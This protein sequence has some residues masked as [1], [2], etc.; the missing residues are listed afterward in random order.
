MNELNKLSFVIPCYR[1]EKTIRSV[2]E[3]I[4]RTVRLREG[5]AYEIIAVNDCS[6]DDVMRVLVELAG[7]DENFKVV[8]CAKN[9]GKH[10]ALM[11]GFR[12]V[13]GDVA[14]CVDDDCQCPVDQLWALLAPIEAGHDVAM[15]D[16]GHKAQSNV[17]NIGSLGNELMMRWLLGKPKEF[18]FSNFAAIRRFIVDEMLKYDHN[19][20]YVNGLILRST[21]DYVNVP[22]TERSRTVGRGGFTFRK[23][24]KLWINGITGFSI[25]PLRLADILGCAFAGIGLIGAIVSL[26]L[27]GHLDVRVAAIIFTMF[28][29][30][31]ILL[32]MLGLVGEYVGRTYMAVNHS[33]QYVIRRT[34]NIE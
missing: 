19:Y 21:N 34:W 16:Y 29:I 31:G 14:I 18:H 30:G 1:S 13:T 3:E 24:M 28:F 11:A 33:P 4:V 25:L 27:S 9:M 22:M 20:S 6:P 7:E 26:I 8:D 32:L 17:K 5:V 10:A 15:A 12:Y 23:S 2:Y